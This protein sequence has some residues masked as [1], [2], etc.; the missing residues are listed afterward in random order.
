MLK[1]AYSVTPVRPSVSVRVRVGVSLVFQLL[2]I[3]VEV[4]Q[5][6]PSVSF[7]HISS[8]IIVCFDENEPAH[9]KTNKMACAHREDSYQPKH[10]PSII[11]VF[12]VRSMG[13]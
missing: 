13:S 10:P 12:A 1:S 11:R 9:D 4:S 2:A 3:C 5:T 8:F 7:G 6:E